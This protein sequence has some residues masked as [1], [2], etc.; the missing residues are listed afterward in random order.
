MTSNVASN[1]VL[2]GDFSEVVVGMWNGLDLI[3]DPYSLASKGCV[4]IVASMYVDV[5]LRRA[6]AVVGKILKA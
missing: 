3:V 5:K 4:K 6:G 2:F 1:G